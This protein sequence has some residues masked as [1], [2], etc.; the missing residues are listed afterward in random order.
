MGI[1]VDLEDTPRAKD[2][3]AGFVGGPVTDPLSSRSRRELLN[4]ESKESVCPMKSNYMADGPILT[5]KSVVLPPPKKPT[6]DSGK[7]L[8]DSG[9]DSDNAA[10]NNISPTRKLGQTVKG[11]QGDGLHVP[12]GSHVDAASDPTLPSE[13]II[14]I[15]CLVLIFK[16]SRL[17]P[18]FIQVC[19]LCFFNAVGA[20]KFKCTL[21]RFG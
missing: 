13:V 14:A 18:T 11:I 17:D 4:S 1:I 8:E 5:P 20:A 15:C 2:K 19:N 12:S 6:K 3:E 10:Q 7:S 21:I 9:S 16:F